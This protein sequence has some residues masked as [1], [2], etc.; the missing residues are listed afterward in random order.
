M[1]LKFRFTNFLVLAAAVFAFAGFASAQ[2]TPKETQDNAQT[3]EKPGRKGFG[4]HDGMR[5]DKFGG[6]RG[7]GGFGG[8]HGIELTDVQKEQMKQIFEANKPSEAEM[9]EMKAFRESRNAGTELT[10]DQ[11]AQ[12]KAMHEARRAKM[13]SV[14]QQILAIL[15]PEQKAQ[16]ETQKAEHQKR[17]Q[18][19]REMWEKRK[20]ERDAAKPTETKPIDN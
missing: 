8:L 15:T 20:A 11:K 1:S 5:G 10:V 12:I 19:R 3:Q 18:E 9:Q 13:E 7:M 6:H 2:E 16:L 4:R 17:M 14:H